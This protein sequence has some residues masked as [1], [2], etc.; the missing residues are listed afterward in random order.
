MLMKGEEL[1]KQA[2]PVGSTP[3]EK[4]ESWG[5][6]ALLPVLVLAA[7]LA[8]LGLL[9]FRRM[10]IRSTPLPEHFRVIQ[11]SAPKIV[12]QH[13]LFLVEKMLRIP[14]KLKHLQQLIDLAAKGRLD[15]APVASLLQELATDLI[16]CD[17][18]VVPA[19]LAEDHQR[20]MDVLL[21]AERSVEYLKSWVSLKPGKERDEALRQARMRLDSAEFQSR[22]L[23]PRL[24]GKP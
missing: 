5:W 2:R 11:T 16:E 8:L 9:V 17:H 22:E 20:V 19:Q 12:A 13:R 15:L 18:A 23:H 7:A 14:R 21:M 3:A 24:M 6:S 1:D 10:F 4:E